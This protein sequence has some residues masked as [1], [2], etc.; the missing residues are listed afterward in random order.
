MPAYLD[1]LKRALVPLGEAMQGRTLVLF[2]SHSAVQNAERALREPLEALGVGVMAQGVD[3]TPR[4]LVEAY[5]RNPKAVLLGTSSF[6]EGVDLSGG[7]IKA[8][9]ISRLPFNVPTDPVFAARSEQYEDPFGQY[10]LPLAVLRFR[11]GFGRLIRGAEDRG[12]VL[13]MDKRVQSRRY[14]AEFL[15][16]LPPCTVRQAPIAELARIAKEWLG[17]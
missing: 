6:W 7:L 15:K 17:G 3:G 16:S 1:A 13:L 11:Q 10:G 14:G 9:V 2:T 4:Q 8:L 12:I 5:A